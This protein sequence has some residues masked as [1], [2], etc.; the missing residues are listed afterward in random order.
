MKKINDN[1]K[2]LI[3]EVIFHN[4]NSAGLQKLPLRL[5]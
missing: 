2:V 1:N 5:E 4:C 3:P